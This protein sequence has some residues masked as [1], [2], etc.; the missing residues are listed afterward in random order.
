MDRMKLLKSKDAGKDIGWDDTI[1]AWIT[2]GY[3]LLFSKLY[4]DSLSDKEIF[5][6]IL[7]SHTS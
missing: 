5:D 1:Q 2:E 7:K 4:S 3:A 6:D